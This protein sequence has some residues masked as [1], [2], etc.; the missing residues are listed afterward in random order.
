[1]SAFLGVCIFQVLNLRDLADFCIRC[2]GISGL[3]FHNLCPS[4]G[5]VSG[6]L[7]KSP[8]RSI[9]HAVELSYIHG[10]QGRLWYWLDAECPA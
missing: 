8:I 6:Y 10:F 4:H 7:T 2:P 9:R 1:M 3:E 5:L